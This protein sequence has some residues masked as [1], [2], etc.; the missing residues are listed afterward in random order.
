MIISLILIELVFILSFLQNLSLLSLIVKQTSYFLVASYPSPLDH[1]LIDK[2]DPTN[3][4]NFHLVFNPI[5][6]YIN[7]CL[8]ETGSLDFLV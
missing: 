6:I 8:V 4:N 3:T 1:I 7:T 5:F 2:F